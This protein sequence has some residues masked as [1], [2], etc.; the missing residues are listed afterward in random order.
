MLACARIGA[1]HSVVF[2]GFAP[3]QLAQRLEHAEPKIVISASCGFVGPK[4]VAYKPLM[5]KAIEL[6]R[7]KPA[8]SI[9]LQARPS[10]APSFSYNFI[11]EKSSL[12]HWDLMDLIGD[13]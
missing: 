12:V 1:V 10:P 13:R 5:D 2:G 8:F 11:R 4:V 3:D 6:S 9:V 7:H